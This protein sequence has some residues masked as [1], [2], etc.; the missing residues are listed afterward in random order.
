MLGAAWARCMCLKYGLGIRA[1]NNPVTKIEA[2]KDN[3]PRLALR[4]KTLLL[5]FIDNLKFYRLTESVILAM[6]KTG[7]A[8]FDDV[9][10]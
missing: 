4:K 6:N 1:S 7:G 3:E 9:P 10:D 2:T 5:D 8:C